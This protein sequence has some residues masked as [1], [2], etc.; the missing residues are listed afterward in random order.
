MSS[1]LDG[2]LRRKL[3]SGTTSKFT[4]IPPQQNALAVY[5]PEGPLV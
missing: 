3:G 5:P 1:S 2:G 4:T